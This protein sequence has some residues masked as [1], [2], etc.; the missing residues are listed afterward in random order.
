[1]EGNKR[2]KEDISF[3]CKASLHVRQF[4]Q[5]NATESN[6][7]INWRE[8]YQEDNIDLSNLEAS[9][10]KR[11]IKEAIFNL[12]TNKSPGLDGFPSSFFQKFWFI[13]KDDL[14]RLFNA[15][16][17][18]STEPDRLNYTYTVLIPKK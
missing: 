7:N 15:I 1:M 11:E 16:H 8:I 4:L 17:S 18:H 13:I 14:C 12:L 2:W 3:N 5:Y 6:L 10:S 9:F